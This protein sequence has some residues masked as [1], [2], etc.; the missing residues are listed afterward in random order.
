MKHPKYDLPPDL[1]EDLTT[2]RAAGE[3]AM[4]LRVEPLAISQMWLLER[5]IGVIGVIRVCRHP[6]LFG[7]AIGRRNS[8][9]RGRVPARSSRLNQEEICVDGLLLVAAGLVLLCADS[10]DIALNLAGLLLA[11][12]GVVRASDGW[13]YYGIV[14]GVVV[15]AVVLAKVL[16]FLFK[17]QGPG[18]WTVLARK[19]EEDR[20]RG[21]RPGG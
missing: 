18:M 12:A 16:H 13:S 5:E 14:G 8:G 9:R 15:G 20:R 6:A 10:D 4:L 1:T 17:P 3:A 19:V 21:R 7:Q 11:S 2:K